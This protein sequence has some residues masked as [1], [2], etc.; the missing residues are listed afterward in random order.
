MKVY[1]KNERRLVD[2][3]GELNKTTRELIA[4]KGSNVSKEIS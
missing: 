1:L 4:L 2:A 3:E